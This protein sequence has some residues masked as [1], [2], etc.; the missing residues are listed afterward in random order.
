M[1]AIE[2]H[3]GYKCYRVCTTQAVKLIEEKLTEAGRPFRTKINT[4]KK[5]GREFMILLLD[6]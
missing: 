4:S 5:R 1:M 3:N 6:T 2:E